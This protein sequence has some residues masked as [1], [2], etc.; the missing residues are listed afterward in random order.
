MTAHVKI[1]D[2]LCSQDRDTQ[3]TIWL[4]RCVQEIRHNVWDLHALQQI[5]DIC[6]LYSETPATN[7]ARA[8]HVVYRQEVV[9][10]LQQRHSLVILITD[11]L[12]AYMERVRSTVEDN[13]GN[14]DPNTYLPDGRYSHVLQVWTMLSSCYFSILFLIIPFALQVQERLTFLRFLLKDGH[15]RLPV[16]QV[17]QIWLCLVERAVFA[18]DRE[19]C[20][21]WFSN[22]MG[23]EPFL[24]PEVSRQ[25]FNDQILQLGPGLM[26][27]SGLKCFNRFFE[28]LDKKKKYTIDAALDYLCRVILFGS[29]PVADKYDQNYSGFHW[30]TCI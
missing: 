26:T 16:L 7:A 30:F 10:R 22:L 15:L 18:A 29:D 17:R 19:T 8:Q 11:N 2:Y 14:Y 13:P 5:R 9:T 24:L 23:Q 12:C 3:K 20:F 6:R 4:D 1:L 25:F 21:K 28:A 27:E